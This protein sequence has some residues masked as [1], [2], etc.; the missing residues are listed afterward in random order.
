[1]TDSLA[2]AQVAWPMITVG[3]FLLLGYA[4][5]VF[6]RRA[7]VPRVTL[8]LLVG[9]ALSPNAL[10]VIPEGVAEWFPLASEVAL[11]MVG[12]MLGERFLAKR[13]REIGKLVIVV[14]VAES[15]CA[16]LAVLVGLLIV[17]VPIEMALILAGIA[18]ASAPA[19]TVDVVREA[20]ASGPLTDCVLSV[21]AIDD[22]YGILLFSL[23]LAASQALPGDSFSWQILMQASWEIVGAI[24]LGALI[25][26]PMAW[27]SG[28]ARP[29]ELTL[30]ETLGFV[31]LCGGIATF[32][33]VSYLMASITLGAFVANRAK[34]HERPFHAIEGISQP[35]LVVFF[36]LAGFEFDASQFTSFGLAGITYVFARSIGKLGGGYLGGWLAGAPAEVRRYVGWCLLPQAGVALGLGLLAAQRSPHNGAAILSLVVGTTFLFEILGPIATRIALRSAGEIPPV[37][38]EG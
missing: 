6:G 31:L 12:F 20:G 25:G 17:G 5:H 1:L 29:G 36:L 8:L 21:V 10:G 24:G 30:V 27:V 9:V 3:A 19:A 4:A 34:H 26:I 37:S 35:F 14:S 2:T 16:A 33:D 22:V 23:L 7:H 32:L 13:I 28:R 11:S 15:V 18:P 38:E